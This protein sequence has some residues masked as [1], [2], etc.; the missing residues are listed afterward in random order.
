M[1]QELK[2]RVALVTG[3]S[4]G[5]GLA[6]AR[7]LAQEGARVAIVSRSA[8]N[9]DAATALLGKEN[10]TVLP[11]VA[12][13][14]DPEQAERA[15]A[16]AEAALGPID[17]LVNSAGAAKRNEPEDLDPVRWR[18]ALDAKFFP[19]IHAEH[20]VLLRMRARAQAA[21][22]PGIPPGAAGSIVNIV[23]TGGKQPTSTHLAGGSANA[24]LMLST[25]G[26]ASHYARYGIRIN[27]I[28]PG[29]TL[30]DRIDQAVTLE[31]ERLGIS[32]EQALADGQAR[33]PLGRYARPEEVAEVAL[34]L[35]SDRASYVVGAIIPLDGGSNPVI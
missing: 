25:V 7:R 1:T 10:I 2:G 13:L 6:V 15:V 32:K 16:A 21:A 30:T 34:F 3:G 14:I 20:A 24:A 27:A 28:N 26:L 29:F 22:K 31:S 4:K 11:L 18:A 5:I 33:V 19:Y 17:I 9:L 35:A 12:D 23:G 8:A